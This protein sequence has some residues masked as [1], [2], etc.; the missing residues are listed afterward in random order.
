MDL[1]TA[2]N[3]WPIKNGLIQDFPSLQHT[4]KTDVIVMGAGISGALVADLLCK[5]GLEVVMLDKRHSGHGSTAAST[6]LLQYEIDTPLRELIKKV[7]VDHAVRS[8]KLC[9]KS[10]H[11]LEKLC[12]KFPHKSDFKLKPS[13][14][15]T[16]KA[17]HL[18]NHIEEFN[19]RNLHG[20]STTEW[21]DSKEI[22]EKFGLKKSGGILSSDGAEVDPFKLTHLLIKSHWKKNLKLFDNTKVIHIQHKKRGVVVKT[23]TGFEIHAKKLV[24]ACG[25]ESQKYLP[26]KIEVQKSTY[27]IVSEVINEKNLWY[28]NALIWETAEPYLY[29]RK[30][31]DHRILIG[32]KDD[33]FYNPKKRDAALFYK[34]RK[35]EEEFHQMFPDIRFKTDY[36]WAGTF[37][38][39]KDG[40]PYI[41]SIPERPHTYFALG[42]GGN[43]ITFSVIAS[44][45]IADLI[46]NRKNEDQVLFSFNR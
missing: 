13:F 26:K 32:G 4:L 7:G 29:L 10:I 9:L 43:G 30:T 19:L 24:I 17:S 38:G 1:H 35:L 36:Q 34:A 42:F 44:Q 16:S 31:A 20:I 25:Y 40:L 21:L 12:N 27:A 23:D 18:K 33:D 22:E 11:D 2:E 37:C 46:F 39:T 15:F 3:F 6:A 28:K 8:Y 14:Q 45:I 5:E 41:G